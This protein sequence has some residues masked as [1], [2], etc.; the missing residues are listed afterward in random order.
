MH[1]HAPLLSTRMRSRLRALH[2][3]NARLAWPP[4]PPITAFVSLPMCAR[5]CACSRAGGDN[6]SLWFWDWTSGHCFQQNETLVQPGSLE[7]EA[8]INA[9]G[10]D[11]R[12]GVVGWRTRA[13]LE[14]CPNEQA[15]GEGGAPDTSLR[16]R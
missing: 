11:V 15:V 16:R 4:A 7:A 14:L 12:W 9:L 8:G 10:F 3:L 5:A 2:A 1:A 6:G 13:A